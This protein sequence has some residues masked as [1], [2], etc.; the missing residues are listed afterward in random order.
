VALAFREISISD[1]PAVFDVRLSTRENAVTLAE[2]ERVHGITPASL[3]LALRGRARGWLCEEAGRALGFALGDAASGEVL[4][5][6]V[7]PEH[8][9]RGIGGTVLARVRDWLF[10]EGHAEI[11]LRANPDPALRSFGFYRRLGWR[12]DSPTEGGEER[13]ILRRGE[14]ARMSYG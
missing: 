13:M 5:V 11:W 8:E 10:A 1:L 14:R 9:G 12:S 6:A 2:L 7:R 3:A 4:V